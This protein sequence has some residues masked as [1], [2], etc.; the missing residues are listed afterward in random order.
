MLLHAY[1]HHEVTSVHAYSTC[2]EAYGMHIQGMFYLMQ[3][4]YLKFTWTSHNTLKQIKKNIKMKNE[5]H[6]PKDKK[7]YMKCETIKNLTKIK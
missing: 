4:H 1:A 2:C 7:S 5:K 6:Q 3:L